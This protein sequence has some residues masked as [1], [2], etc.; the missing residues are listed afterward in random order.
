M[1]GLRREDD[2]VVDGTSTENPTILVVDDEA[3]VRHFL[4][5]ILERLGYTVQTASGG[6]E[7]IDLVREHSF[8]VVLTDLI[9]PRIDGLKVIEGVKELSPETQ[10]VV[11]T[12]YPSSET[13]VAATRA[14]ALDYLPKS[15]DPEHLS[16][17]VEK[18]MEIRSLQRKAKERDFYLRMAQMDGLTEL[19]NQQ[20]FHRFLDQEFNRS[21]RDDSPISLVFADIDDFAQ[22]NKLSGRLYGDQLLQQVGLMLK[23]TCRNYDIVARYGAD[24]FAILAPA[25]DKDGGTRLGHRVN[26]AVKDL[27][28][29]LGQDQGQISMSVGVAAFPEDASESSR[30]LD[31]AEEAL[32]SARSEGPGIVITI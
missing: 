4:R 13:I 12:G 11:I 7:A 22:F 5:V 1:S 25:T 10:V 20:S 8:D 32:K 21:K 26:E 16:V 14:G 17:L 2:L 28:P 18:A 6:A 29:R 19:L 9:M 24:E 27:R 3:P 31:K 30:L 23:R 15:P